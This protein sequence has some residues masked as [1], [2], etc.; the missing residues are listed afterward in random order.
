M[1]ESCV[2]IS[3]KSEPEAVD[4][5]Q[6]GGNGT[7]FGRW[8]DQPLSSSRYHEENRKRYPAV[9]SRYRTTKPG[10]DRRGRVEDVSVPNADKHKRW[11]NEEKALLAEYNRPGQIRANLLS[12][13][14]LTYLEMVE[15]DGRM[16][17]AAAALCYLLMVDEERIRNQKKG[18][19]VIQS[20]GSEARLLA[21]MKETLTRY[22]EHDDNH[23]WP[24]CLLRVAFVFVGDVANRWL[25]CTELFAMAA[26]SVTYERTRDEA[27]CMFGI[28]YGYTTDTDNDNTKLVVRYLDRAIELSEQHRHD[29]L[30]PTDIR[31]TAG[32]PANH[33]RV[34]AAACFTK[35]EVLMKTARTTL[36]D[37]PDQAL[38]AVE[39]AYGLVKELCRSSGQ[40]GRGLR[41]SRATVAYELGVRY[42]VVGVPDRAAEFFGE[43]A[44]AASG[45][46][47]DLVLEAELEAARLCPEPPA[48][49]RDAVFQ[50]I[51]ADALARRNVPVLVRATAARGYV[52][53][54]E[55]R[56]KE[57]H[58]RFAVAQQLAVDTGHRVD[59]SIRFYTAVNR[60]WT[61]L[62]SNLPAIR[63]RDYDLLAEPRL[64]TGDERPLL[65]HSPT[66]EIFLNADRIQ[67]TVVGSDVRGIVQK[68]NFPADQ[69]EHGNRTD[70]AAPDT[71]TIAKKVTFK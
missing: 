22:T 41:L 30:L 23:S 10:R 34:W 65:I 1:S 14:D 66:D 42:T 13:A 39:T 3:E 6:R 40:Q 2:Q 71:I 21:V 45:L 61:F 57:A 35:H 31:D 18:S 53:M 24:L 12:A 62:Q 19:E 54:E 63:A 43:C 26:L 58:R 32:V 11:L 20:V 4:R 67:D 25:W 27:I 7:E 5:R 56:P 52:A 16:D 38:L 47:A 59:D 48:T 8:S 44:A 50:R 64:W 70:V 17:R 33:N 69:P 60:T 37:S 15:A 28:G 29:W 51:A 49:G 55:G 46:D 68:L 36:K 9:E